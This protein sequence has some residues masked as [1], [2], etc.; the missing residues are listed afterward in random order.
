MY[1]CKKQR[2]LRILITILTVLII[3]FIFCQSLMP[4]EVS[5]EES[6]RVVAFLNRITTLVGLGEPF[7]QAFVRTCAHFSEFAV[8][9]ISLVLTYRSYFSKSANIIFL[10]PLS[11]TLIAVA[12][13]CIQLFSKGRAFQFSDIAIDFC[14]ALCGSLL[15]FILMLLKKKHSKAT[16]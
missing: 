16:N 10:T 14:G 11:F 8:L 9:G 4:G 3:C 13:E 7:T 6:G 5:G 1:S 15:I 12:D 2:I